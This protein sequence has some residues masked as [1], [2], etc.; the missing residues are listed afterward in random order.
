MSAP[1]AVVATFTALRTLAV[2]GAGDGDGSVSSDPAGVACTFTAGASAGDC[3]EPFLDGTVVIL[4]AI[5]GSGSTFT[6]WSGACSG[7]NP[8]VAVTLTLVNKSCTAGFARNPPAQSSLTVA[9]EGDGGGVVSS[10]P[11]GIDCHAAQGQ[12]SGVCTA[13]F[14]L[15]TEVTLT[16]LAADD[17]EFTGWGGDADC[18]DGLIVLTEQRQCLARFNLTTRRLYLPLVRR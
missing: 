2:N 17:A 18:N 9:A 3:A 12:T 7:S 4:T 14:A 16:A 6:G 8:V 15:G 1:K 5:A 10:T 11:P 13:S